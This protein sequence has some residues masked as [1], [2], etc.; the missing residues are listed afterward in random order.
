MISQFAF[1]AALLL[2]AAGYSQEADSTLRFAFLTDTHL[3]VDSK[4]CYD[5][6]RCIADINSSIFVVL[7]TYHAVINAGMN[8]TTIPQ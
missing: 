7:T 4:S 3:S 1:T 8:C 2:G 6:R 5:L